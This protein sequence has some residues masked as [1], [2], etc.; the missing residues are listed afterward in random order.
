MQEI[1]EER[2]L[3]RTGAEREE[4][5]RHAMAINAQVRA[6]VHTC[7]AA[8]TQVWCECVCP[9]CAREGKKVRGGAHLSCSLGSVRM[10]REEGKRGGAHLSFSLCFARMERGEERRGST[11]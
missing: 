3:K 2:R 10:G 5:E 9:V 4:N 11:L 6:C 8:R 7:Y 1:E